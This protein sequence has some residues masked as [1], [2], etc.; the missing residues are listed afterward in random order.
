MLETNLGLLTGMLK[1]KDLQRDQRHRC[2]G[3]L[4][5]L[6]AVCSLTISVATRYSSSE[7]TSVSKSATLQK[8]R[9]PQARRQHLTKAA[10]SWGPPVIDAVILKPANSY[11]RVVLSVPPVAGALF[12]NALFNRPPPRS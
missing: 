8:Y 4:V 5:I 12:A 3:V 10:A 11:P 9:S 1:L 6:I 7:G 2:W